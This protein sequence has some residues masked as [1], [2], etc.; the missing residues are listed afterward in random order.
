QQRWAPRSAAAM[1]GLAIDELAGPL[2]AEL[3]TVDVTY[4]LDAEWELREAQRKFDELRRHSARWQ[5]TL[6]DEV[7]DLVADIE[8][9]LRDR[10]RK[11]LREVDAFFDVA[12]PGTVWDGF[13]PWLAENMLR[14]AEANFGW[15]V[16]R[17]DWIARTIAA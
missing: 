10:T 4:A 13:Q 11:I 16:A 3:S 7:A 2:R 6:G 17:A 9:D 5:N 8:Y 12:D 14:A 15:L 1:V